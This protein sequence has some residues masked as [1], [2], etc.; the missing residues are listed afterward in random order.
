MSSKAPKLTTIQYKALSLIL[1]LAGAACMTTTAAHAKEKDLLV[2]AIDADREALQRDDP[3]VRRVIK[4]LGQA[5]S[6][7]NHRVTDESWFNRH[8]QLGRRNL[9][10]AAEWVREAR[11]KGNRAD[12]MITLKTYQIRDHRRRGH[13][14]RV[15]VIARIYTLPEGRVDLE[16]DLISIAGA[17]LP[18]D[19]DRDVLRVPSGCR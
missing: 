14:T 12:A 6:E 19:C 3:I 17:I 5:L 18:P 15:E 11:R 4:M 7:R 16:T 10:S 2:V 1:L 9:T 8:Q 13:A